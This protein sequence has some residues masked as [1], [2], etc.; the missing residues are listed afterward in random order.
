LSSE[1][2]SIRAAAGI[3]PGDPGP[4]VGFVEK[5]TIAMSQ[6]H[7]RTV[8][9]TGGAMGIGRLFAQNCLR[10]EGA[11]RVVLWDVNGQA[12]EDTAH[13]LREAGHSVDTYVVDVSS[14]EQI[15]RTAETVLC[16]VG[17]I[18]L[19]VN[20]AGIVVGKPFHEHSPQEI[21]K[22]IAV[23][24]RGVMHVARVFLPS[25]IER[26]RGHILNV[27]SAAGYLPNPN[28]SVYA[29]S[30]W[31]VLG[32]SESMRIELEQLPGDLHVTT[33]TP[34]YINTGM[35]DGVTAPLLTP[36]LE[37]E[38]IVARMIRAVKT[39]KLVVKAPFMVRF[40][41][42]FRAILPPRL[43]DFFVGRTFGVYKTM[44]T[45]RGRPKN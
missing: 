39:N 40:V 32:W 4:R 17:P 15:E 21:E 26:G 20:N 28:M 36:I 9:I 23:N 44:D 16:D 12:L 2:A 1:T 6:I 31:A 5:G 19:L 22:T 24:V 25:M 33:L 34:S 41:P 43:F 18:D 37:P 30:K 45:F 10:E 38:R 42:L 7:G 14:I 13:E 29:A 8:L 11:A 35:F 3:L 27:A